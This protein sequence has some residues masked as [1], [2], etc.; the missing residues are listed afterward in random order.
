MK[1][2]FMKEKQRLG[3]MLVRA[4]IITQEQLEKALIEQRDKR[5]RLGKT[6]TKLGF[7]SEE[8]IL[9]FLGSQM[10]IPYIDLEDIEMERFGKAL[11]D[12][13]LEPIVRR[14][15]AV[16]IG[17]KDNVLTV[18]M[19]DPLDIFAIDEI[20]SVTGFEVRPV[21]AKEEQIKAIIDKHYRGE[22]SIE[23]ILAESDIKKIDFV[24]EDEALDL[25]R[26]REEGEAA[27]I[28]RLVNH[29]IADAMEKGASD[30]HIEPYE[31]ELR[32]RFRVDG[33]LFQVFSPPKNLHRAIV[34]R[35]KIIANLNIAERRLPQDGRCTIRLKAKEA[36]LRI[37]IIPTAYGE[38]V[39]IR[40]LDPASLC[41][42]LSML[43]MSQKTMGLYERKIQE[44][45]GIILVTGPTGCGKTT[46]LYSTLKTLNS[47][48]KNI[49]T[50]EDPVEYKIKGLNQM[51]A[52]P[53]IGL[54]FA[55]GLRSFMRQDPD[56]I[57]VGEIRD[58][59]TAEVAINAALTGHLVF[60]TLHT[61]D[62]V[63][64]IIRLQNMGVEP[65]LI[66]S[67]FILSVAQRLIRKIC[68][69]CK[70]RTTPSEKFLR[71]L[72]ISHQTQLFR[73]AGCK[74][75]LNTGY[76]GRIGIYEL[77]D[78]D[79][80]IQELITD[81]ESAKRIEELALEKG[82]ISLRE[83][84]KEKLLSGVTTIEEIMK[85]IVT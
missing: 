5:E 61:N 49:L 35:V 15:L 30:I 74:K 18:A 54:E 11:R 63:G 80:D 77:L 46:T 19:A 62:S 71:I 43:G 40:I 23:K 70:E 29:F 14:H 69:E 85:V 34:S 76:K 38:K 39:V 16:P 52:K 56:I 13:V 57:F 36:D 12:D 44:P 22:E 47:P 28:I 64:A 55:V 84:A 51:Q 1:S 31:D 67:T 8:T 82:F 24:G 2:K 72:G 10:N 78:I 48:D 37:S 66:A 45:H 79:V 3:D 17:L 60:S 73:G 33:I 26:I 42:D 75:C 50:I 81:R 9:N 7:V 21:V 65:F 59:E 83:S 53:E 20:Q 41:V 27:T 32:V 6:L 4:N 58:K 68:P 25:D